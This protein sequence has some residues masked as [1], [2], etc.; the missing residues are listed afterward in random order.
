MLGS[1]PPLFD[2][3]AVSGP[4]SKGCVNRTGLAY[5]FPSILVRMR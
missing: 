1:I 4:G 3:R 5:S 2:Y